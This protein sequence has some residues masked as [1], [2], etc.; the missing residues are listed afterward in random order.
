[1]NIWRYCS[2]LL[3]TRDPE[4]RRAI[5]EKRNIHKQFARIRRRRT[6]LYKLLFSRHPLLT[7]VYLIPPVLFGYYIAVNVDAEID[8][9]L[10]QREL[11]VAQE[12]ANTDT[13]EFFISYVRD[14]YSRPGIVMDDCIAQ[15]VTEN[16]QG[17]GFQTMD[18]LTRKFFFDVMSHQF[19]HGKPIPHK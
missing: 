5:K 15:Y 6:W 14:C 3:T 7:F 12:S 8:F 13:E 19:N 18:E 11:L 4:S 1:M 2:S 9:R 17:V 10:N 16:P